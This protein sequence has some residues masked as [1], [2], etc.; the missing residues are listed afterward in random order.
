VHKNVGNLNNH[1]GVPLTLT[2]LTPAHDV[3]VMEMGM[4]ARGEIRFLASLCRPST[5]VLTNA[6]AAHLEQL[7]T[8]EEVA[9]AKSELAEAISADGLLVLNADDP[10]LWPMN[11]TRS[12][13]VRSYALEN[14]EADLRPL[15][16]RVTSSGGTRFTLA[17]GTTVGL[18]LLGTHNARNALA[19][20]L[21]GDRFGVPR[22]EA[23]R[24]LE[25]LRPARRRLELHTTPAGVS[26]LDDAYNANPASM[27]EAL[28]LLGSM[29]TKGVRRAALGDMLELG[30]DA[31]RLHEEAGRHMP[32]DGWLYVAGTFAAALERGARAAGVPASRIRRFD[33][34]DAMA[35]A[36][37]KDAASGD[38]VLVKA[39]RGMRLER[40]VDALVPGPTV[41]GTAPERA[42][43]R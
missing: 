1:I 3:L 10:L 24:A 11:R 28:S 43:R 32:Q 37:A 40:V 30:P 16:L 41:R 42:G 31:E 17:D 20:I 14:P 39:S 36:V 21:V 19:A 29:E 12:A 2:K 26:V 6:S 35:R 5:G 22:D 8:I 9:L 23:A 25:S 13:T 7:G 38:L 15:E 27:R 34:V 4:S 18:S 33:D